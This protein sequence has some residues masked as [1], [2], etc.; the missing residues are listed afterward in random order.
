MCGPYVC[1]SSSHSMFLGQ[2]VEVGGGVV[3][4]WH[5]TSLDAEAQAGFSGSAYTQS[6]AVLSQQLSSSICPPLR[7]HD[8]PPH[9]PGR[10]CVICDVDFTYIYILY[11]KQTGQKLGFYVY[12]YILYKCIYVLEISN[13]SLYIS[14]FQPPYIPTLP[15]YT[16]SSCFQ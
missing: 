9:T 1:N 10:R 7:I 15:L 16:V 11:F 13:F 6:Y 8:P 2:G 12:E 3:P 4:W 5:G 14:S